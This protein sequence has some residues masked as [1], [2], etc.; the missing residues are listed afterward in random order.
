MKR[1]WY[2][3]SSIDP[4]KTYHFILVPRIGDKTANLKEGVTYEKNQKKR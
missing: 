4:N 3:L 1:K 2:Q